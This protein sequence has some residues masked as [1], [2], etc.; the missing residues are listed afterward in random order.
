VQE[1][2]LLTGATGLLG[3]YLLRDLLLGGRRVAVV[4]RPSKKASAE[5]RV[6]ATM[7]RWEGLEK[8]PLPRP[9]VFEGDVGD[10]LLGLDATSR[11]WIATNCGSILHNAALLNFHETS[12]G[13]PWKTNVGGTKNVLALCRQVR[14][15]DLHYVSTAY[16][17][18]V[19][20]GTVYEDELDVG[21]G[22]RNDYE[23]S[24]FQAEELVREDPYLD[25]LTVYRPAVISGDSVNGYTNT[26]HGIYLYLRLMCMLVPQQELDEHGRR[27]TPIRVPMTGEEKRNVFPVD[28]VSRVLARLFQTP[29]AHGRTY[30]LSPERCLTPR[31]GIEA[32]YEYFNSTGL[33]FVG[34]EPIE[35]D[36]SNRFE[37]EILANLAMYEDYEST[38]PTFDRTN[39]LEFAA[40]LPCPEIDRA[41]LR[42]YMEHGEADRW[43]KRR[44]PKPAIDFS[45]LDYLREL[46]N[47]ST[48]EK[49]QAT[50]HTA[51]LDVVG[52]G[53][54]QWTLSLDRYRVVGLQPGVTAGCHAV[55]RMTSTDF[56]D[57]VHRR[58]QEPHSYLEQR[59]RGL[60]GESREVARVLHRCLFHKPAYV[61]ATATDH[62]SYQSASLC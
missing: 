24:K 43:G 59:L 9:V 57:L 11:D 22:F 38:D 60:N 3:C 47:D 54:G 52:P 18:G 6:E 58:I 26:Y 34:Y 19:R 21:Q 61:P 48:R 8:R 12:D 55:L 15:R 31:E 13:E 42:R 7:Q 27:Y 62:M 2:V 46:H 32:A 28:W 41:M 29:A 45:V 40:D 23:R 56:A 25:S 35:P 16:V 10:D 36:P 1:Y 50:S 17:C 37:T 53:G 33:Q 14:I 4:V 30:H 49:T 51:A 20:E 39:L 5:D 44:D